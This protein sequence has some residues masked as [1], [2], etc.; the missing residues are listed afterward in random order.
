MPNSSISDPN[1]S[2]GGPKSPSVDPEELRR[3]IHAAFTRAFGL[4][5]RSMGKD[6]QWGLRPG[7]RLPAI[8]VLV[9]GSSECPII[10]IFDPHDHTDGVHHEG[11]Y[12]EA[13][14]PRIV[15][16]IQ[17]KVKQAVKG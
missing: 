17:A 13:A 14:V 7:P 16:L 3:L 1:R 12:E 10:W 11:I 6:M 5:N 2:Q 4:P 8:N 9:N 15:E